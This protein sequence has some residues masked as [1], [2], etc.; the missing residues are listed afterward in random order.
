MSAQLRA[1]E[2]FCVDHIRMAQWYEQTL[3]LERVRATG[4]IITLTDGATDILFCQGKPET[5]KNST[6]YFIVNDYET[7]DQ[8][9]CGNGGVKVQDLA[10]VREDDGI[11]VHSALYEDGE[12][13]IL[14]LFVEQAA[15]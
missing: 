3:G 6:L 15:T 11:A 14:A 10:L 8:A 1:I 13:N 9:I 7:V 5:Y 4:D 12:R 2:L